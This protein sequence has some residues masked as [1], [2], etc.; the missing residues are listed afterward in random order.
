MRAVSRALDIV[1]SAFTLLA[2][3]PL[4]L[5][6]AAGI[7]ITI[8]RP[9]FF[10]QV[11]PGA[12]GRPF[13][14]VKFRTMSDSRDEQDRLLPDEERMTHFG[15]ILREISLDELPQLWNVLSGDMA[16]VGPRPLLMEYLPRYNTRQNKRHDVKPGITG[17]AQI[18]GRNAIDWPEKFEMD[19]WYVEHRSLWLDVKILLLTPWTVLGRTGISEEGYATT[20]D[21]LGNGTTAE[22]TES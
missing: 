20:S 10:R 6:I 9:V 3:S 8:G 17:W 22:S 5:L 16:L 15:N 7:V 21:F 19:V 1:L 18:N 14:C 4:L 2:L 13:P 12:H 11:R